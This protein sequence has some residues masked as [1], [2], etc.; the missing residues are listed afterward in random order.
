MSYITYENIRYKIL[1]DHEIELVK[2][3]DKNDIDILAIPDKIMIETKEY[4]VTKICNKAFENCTFLTNISIPSTVKEIESTAFSYN[5]YLEYFEY[6]NIYYLGNESNPYLVLMKV[7][8]KL[9]S[10]YLIHPDTKLIH[11]NA[12]NSCK[13]LENI[14]LLDNIIYIGN[15]AFRGCS[16]LKEIILPSKLNKLSSYAFSKCNDLEQIVFNDKL[17]FIGEDIFKE[18]LKLQ[19]Y[20]ENNG[21]YLG[22]KDNPFYTLIDVIDKK[23][24]EFIINPNTVHIYSESLMSC[25]NI[26]E[27]TIPKNV[28]SIGKRAFAM[29]DLLENVYILNENTFIDESVFLLSPKVKQKN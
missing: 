5:K 15:S 11:A 20:I 14:S 26:K 10:S 2:Y 24:D 13:N 27:I 1:N 4:T 22:S 29:C 16:K 19:Y 18:S 12:F 9:L 25:K 21:K 17:Q 8:N 6:E 3:I 28:K 7:G 23:V